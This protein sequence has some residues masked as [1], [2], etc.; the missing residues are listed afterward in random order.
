MQTQTSYPVFENGQVLSSKHLNDLV[1]YL[2]QQDR[3]TRNK[4]IGIGI[5]CG[6]EVGFEPPANQIRLTGGCAVTSEGYL[7]ALEETL[8]NRF[9]PYTLPTPKL[10]EAP[11]DVLQDARYPFFF[12]NNGDQIALWEVLPVDYTPGPGEPA[13]S[14]LSAAFLQGKV[15]L[16]FLERTLESLRNCDVND[17]SD[18]GSEYQ[19]TPR[20]LL[21]GEADAQAILKAEEEI[22]GRPVHRN[23]HPGLDLGELRLPKINPAANKI[24]TFVELLSR[25]QKIAVQTA[26]QITNDLKAGYQAYAHFLADMYPAAAFP[27]GPFGDANYLLNVVNQVEG[28]IFLVQYLYDYLFDV[29]QSHNEFL[30]AAGRLDAECCP[31]P[32]RFPLHV[33]LGRVAQRP[34]AFDAAFDPG[35]IDSYD[36]LK[37]D[38]GFGA[39][40]RPAVYRHYFIPSPA[41]DGGD[42]RLQEVRSLHYRT[43]LLALRYHTEGLP[44]K[45][46]RITP[47]KSGDYR[48]SDKAIPFYY[49]FAQGDDL[50]RN[51][52]FGK[53]VRN[54]LA[55]VFSHQFVGGANHP[56]Q[57]R[58]D[59][60]N[61]YRVEGIA[62]KGL[63][64]VMAELQRQKRDLGLSFAFEPVFMGLA[65]EGDPASTAMNEEARTRAQQALVKLLMCRVRDLDIVFLLLMGLLFYYLYALITIL[66]RANT[67]VIAGIAA[68]TLNTD[69]IRQLAGRDVL[70]PRSEAKAADTALRQI[71]GQVYQK[72]QLADTLSKDQT[73]ERSIAKLY[74]TLKTDEDP[75]LL[76]DKT[77]AFA[78]TLDA[79]ANPDVLAQRIYPYVALL[80]ASD[81]L[82]ETVSAPS[83]A[84]FNF[85]A[86]ATRY[87]KFAQTFDTYRA[88]AEKQEGLSAEHVAINRALLQNQGAILAAGPQAIVANLV[89]EL[90]KRIQN[91]T[92]E[93]LLGPYAQRHPGMEHQAGV[94]AGGTLV[95]VYTHKA[96][97]LQA[98]GLNR[99]AVTRTVAAFR[100]KATPAAAAQP[101]AL[102]LA[103]AQA[104]GNEVLDDFV[105]LADF[106]LPYLC[107]DTDCSDIDLP[108]PPP[109]APEESKPGMVSGSIFAQR[110]GGDL[111]ASASVEVFRSDTGAVVSV[112]VD[113]GKYSFT[114]PAGKYMIV[115]TAD[116][117][118]LLPDKREVVVEPGSSQNQDFVLQPVKRGTVKG[119]VFGQPPR[120]AP[121]VLAEAEV[122]VIFKKTGKDVDVSFRAGEY[123]FAGEPGEYLIVASGARQG[124]GRE[125][126]NVTLASGASLTEDFTLKRG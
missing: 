5:V 65:V 58:L 50:H 90:Q 89:G 83:L 31:H 45:P 86:F 28:N 55:Q 79:N 44:A 71:R 21:L 104:S 95:L 81:D 68:T 100:Q 64:Q 19:F 8:F 123:G 96:L 110:Q 98:L 106:C 103:L 62:G 47:S 39:A 48:L 115:V 101:I 11:D 77:R 46:I 94:P 120:G 53:T 78:A 3:L 119:T 24:D 70:K 59:D 16:L 12:K 76:Y 92:G 66:R 105:V 22:A 88:I 112:L 85:N 72:G 93:L 27:G 111:V 33:L 114:V 37:A 107:C 117:A 40:A 102:D 10:E 121:V 73:P 6:L 56:L 52:S 109:P 51:W 118:G 26:P 116:E 69:V 91:I 54:R 87:D 41:L 97:L 4:L 82:I 36:P 30:A 80:D 43:Y 57:N 23:T 14:Q 32:G 7:I 113:E 63:G 67:S 122:A 20:L 75:G 49:A 18:R 126:R 15:A 74:A 84:A 125:E 29:V 42:G 38:S 60:Q 1:N 124:F 35:T 17:C 108:A 34:I 25:I 13:P 9:R 2:E 61:F 99:E